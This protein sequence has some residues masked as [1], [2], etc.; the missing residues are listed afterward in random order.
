MVVTL[1]GTW[2]RAN[3]WFLCFLRQNYLLDW[4]LENFPFYNWSLSWSSVLVMKDLTGELS[5]AI[6]NW[7]REASWDQCSE[8]LSGLLQKERKARWLS[9]AC[10]GVR[11]EN[12]G[13]GRSLEREST[14]AVYLLVLSISPLGI[15]QNVS[16]L[17]Y[18]HNSSHLMSPAPNIFI[19]FFLFCCWLVVLTL[20]M[21]HLLGEREQA[22]S[23]CQKVLA[24]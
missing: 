19:I 10:W 23:G 22:L 8:D 9:D 11:I 15:Q 16:V 4:L 17:S 18:L 24:F 1:L 21:L 3:K 20:I 2:Q 13:R 12:W 6:F 5:N 7:L 14:C